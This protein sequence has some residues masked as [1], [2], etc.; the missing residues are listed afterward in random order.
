MF[1]KSVLDNGVRVISE[2]L[3][4][5]RVVS[6]GIWI[7]VGS[8]DEHDLNNGCAHF[9]EHMFFKGTA[10]RSA[11]QI[12]KEF[13]GLGGSVNAFTSR[14]STCLYGTV[15]DNHLSKMVELLSDLFLNS[16][17][18]QEDVERERQVIMQE[19]SMVEDT[20]DDFIHDLFSALIWKSH[21]L[22]RTVL[23]SREVVAS[24]DS[25]RLADYVSRFY[26]PEK[27]VIAAAG[28]VDH[29]ELLALVK[30]GFSR[31]P[32]GKGSSVVRLAP[33]NQEPLRVA[34]DKELEQV[35]MLLGTYGLSSVDDDRY[36][37]LLMNILL[38]GN[39]SSRLFQEVRE[40]RGLAYAVFSD[41][42]SYADC[43]YLA[44]YLGVEPGAAAEAVGLVRREIARLYQ[45]EIPDPELENVKEFVKGGLY[46]AS[47]N[48]DAIMTRIARNEFLFGRYLAIDEVISSIDRVR[49]EEIK[50]LARRLF[51]D[52]AMTVTA[53][54]PLSSEAMNRLPVGGW[55][56]AACDG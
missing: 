11:Q 38:G 51:Y 46:L 21:P 5:S 25:G 23:G 49:G 28:N 20:P 36:A 34:H 16:L 48:M 22:A 42:V 24:M 1:N 52:R 32:Q 44:V 40:K 7:D 14:E 2:Q 3:S 45:E 37:Y 56:N 26:R 15:M 43:G 18:R 6:I 29:Q 9:A 31:L 41:A 19:I 27:I 10:S 53:L 33:A 4:H 55:K 30:E 39:M 35:H 12:A 13:D 50:A 54:G 17:F 47:E 8:R